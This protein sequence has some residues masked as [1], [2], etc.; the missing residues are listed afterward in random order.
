MLASTGESAHRE[1]L[2]K[3]GVPMPGADRDVHEW[4]DEDPDDHDDDTEPMW[5]PGQHLPE[6]ARRMGL[7]HHTVEGALLDFG[8]RLDAS[9]PWHRVTAWA[10]LV[11]F[12]MPV[13]FAVLRLRY[14][15]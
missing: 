4:Y 10:M 2:R 9:K 13:V 8:G 11:V 12:G 7:T 6:D 3:Y 5:F 1:P 15:F 14:L